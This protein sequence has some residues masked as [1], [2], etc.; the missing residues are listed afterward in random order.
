MNIGSALAGVY[1]RLNP[2]LATEDIARR[3]RRAMPIMGYIGANG[4]GKSMLA[5]HDSIPTLKGIHWSCNN[6]D[7]LHTHEG[8]T[9][10]TR[11]VLSTMPFITPSGAPHPLYVPLTDYSQIISAEHVD[12]IL[13]EVGGAV[14][15]TTG[16]DIPMGV[17]A[18]LQELRRREVVCRWTAPSWSRAS[19]VLREVSQGV[20]LTQGFLPVP[21]KDGI[22]FDGPHDIE[23]LSVDA[24]SLVYEICPIEGAHSHPSGR[25]WGARRAMYARTFDATVFDE[26][27]TAKKG[28]LRPEVRSL[29]WRPGSEAE[30]IYDTHGYVE[31]LGQVTDSGRCDH[32]GGTRRRPQCK[33]ESPA[34]LRGAARRAAAAAAGPALEVTEDGIVVDDSHEC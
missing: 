4:A 18:S 29:F 27:T 20:T 5:A 23:R 7:H 16:D 33:C 12:L 19:K 10:G 24:E 15:S 2:L 34:E 30:R 25:L 8:R 3:K 21:H 32:C 14:A 9:H 26:W 6:I 31:K 22:E 17:K 1:N 11:R 13:D 28:K